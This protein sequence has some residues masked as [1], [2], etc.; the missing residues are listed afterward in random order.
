MC[1][2]PWLYGLISFK[3]WFCSGSVDER[4]EMTDGSSVTSVHL[5]AP[6]GRVACDFGTTGGRSRERLS[7]DSLRPLGNVSEGL[8]G[9]QDGV[10][11]F[12]QQQQQATLES[13]C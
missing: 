6:A 12:L 9:D 2:L 11:E 1:H 10:G 5:C 3:K 4:S 13:G 8:E 7:L